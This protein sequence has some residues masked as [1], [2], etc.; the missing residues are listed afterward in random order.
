MPAISDTKYLVRAGLLDVPHVSPEMIA[1]I[2]KDT[3]PFQ[4]DA[5]MLGT[6]SLG[7]GAIYPV[8]E[9]DIKVAPFNIPDT[10]PRAYGMDVGWNRTAVIW[11]ALDPDSEIVYLYTEHYMGH[12]SPAVHAGAIKARGAWIR[13]A[14][15]PA[16]RS[17]GQKDG[18][19]LLVDYREEGLHLHKANNSREAG[20]LDVYRR[21][22]GGTLK[23]FECCPNW[24][25]EY[26]FYRRD[27][28]GKVVKENDHIM[29]ATRYLIVTGLDLMTVEPVKARMMGHSRPADS[30]IGY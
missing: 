5:R 29:D 7:S 24:F 15:D 1:M 21:L 19:Q 14:I 23:V 28:E 18:S 25:A 2:E 27:P 4:R 17:S 22:V 16:S 3:A 10:W 30:V 13:G 8:P 6:P 26:R 20:L 11:G 9:S 12:A